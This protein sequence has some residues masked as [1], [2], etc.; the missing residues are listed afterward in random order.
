MDPLYAE[1][2]G[3]DQLHLTNGSDADRS[4][5]NPDNDSA[6]CQ[7]DSTSSTNVPPNIVDFIVCSFS[8]YGTEKVLVSIC[9]I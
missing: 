2:M 7:P 6:T 5:N 1:N 9:F 8:F 4:K 3:P